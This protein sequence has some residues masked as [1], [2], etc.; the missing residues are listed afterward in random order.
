M[1]V[2]MMKKSHVEWFHVKEKRCQVCSPKT[3]KE[4]DGV[5]G[6]LWNFRLADFDQK[7]K[8]DQKYKFDQ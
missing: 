2:Y 1:Q 3:Q 4:N 6:S 8:S 5:M 7:N